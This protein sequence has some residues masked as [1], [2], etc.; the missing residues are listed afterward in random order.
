MSDRCPGERD[1][2]RPNAT[3]ALPGRD[4]APAHGDLAFLRWMY[5]GDSLRWCPASVSMGGRPDWAG[6]DRVR[7]PRSEPRPLPVDRSGRPY[8]EARTD[9][10]DIY[11]P[12]WLARHN[13]AIF[14]TLFAIGELFV[15][16]RW[17]LAWR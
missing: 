3:E 15:V 1:Y 12:L 7:C 17:L 4:K 10:F 6:T 8:T 13:K 5:R 11:L 16:G 14:G 9:N 2:G